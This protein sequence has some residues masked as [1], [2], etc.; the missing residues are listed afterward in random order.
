VKLQNINKPACGTFLA[1]VILLAASG[2]AQAAPISWGSATS[3]SGDAD[4]STIGTLVG[5][6]NFNSAA[7]TVNSVPFQEFDAEV[8]GLGSGSFTVG[9]FTL[10]SNFFVAA[11]NTSSA[12]APFTA[13]SAS[14]QALLA[15]SAT[16]T[17]DLTLTLAGLT[18][19]QQYNFQVW[20]NNSADY[21]H[22]GVTAKDTG[23]TN[24]VFLSSG[25]GLVNNYTL[26][27]YVIG[28]FIADS[29]SQQV[30][31]SPDE[32]AHVNGFQLR[33][34]TASNPIPEPASIL[35]FG[36]GLAVL[37]ASR[38]SRKKS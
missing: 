3:I 22:F 31:F 1:A 19:G 34:I 20:S 13:L 12:T 18:V 30:L 38:L 33:A 17:G 6:F 8:L 26:G 32:V 9:N 24:S 25:S 10:A 11:A 35:I 15:K 7:T 36:T 21:P 27:N 23:L 5:A 37:T 28:T 14:Y 16:A 29:A 4:V 2:T